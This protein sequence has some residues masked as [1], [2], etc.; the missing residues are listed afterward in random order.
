MVENLRGQRTRSPLQINSEGKRREMVR[1][2]DAGG[3]EAPIDKKDLREHSNQ[4]Q[5]YLNLD[6]NNKNHYKA[7]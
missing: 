4:L 6:L 7:K 3:G 1:G 5:P 2:Q